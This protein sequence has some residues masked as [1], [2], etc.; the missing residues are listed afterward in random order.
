MF[1]TYYLF[2]SLSTIIWN[3]NSNVCTIIVSLSYHVKMWKVCNYSLSTY[4]ILFWYRT[5]FVMIYSRPIQCHPN[6]SYYPLS[7]IAWIFPFLS[8]IVSLITII[9][10]CKK[11][12]LIRYWNVLHWSEIALG[13]IMNHYCIIFF[14]SNI[15]K[16]SQWSGFVHITRIIQYWN[17]L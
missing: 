17:I 15:A 6:V 8:N 14:K 3:C 10:Y 16:P 5:K 7:M 11:N 9:R 13:T 12:N 4:S 1:V 2:L